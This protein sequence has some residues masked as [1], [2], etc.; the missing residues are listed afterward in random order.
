MRKKVAYRLIYSEFWTDPFIQEDMTPEDR[1]F[2][3]YI[4][5]NPHTTMAGI[6][7]ITK[8]QIAFELGYSIES[9]NSL[10]DRFE[11]HHKLIK[12]NKETREIAIKNWGK[13]NLNKGGKPVVDCLKKELVSIKDKTLIA[14]VAIYVKSDV[15][16]KLYESYN[17]SY[18]ESS[19]GQLNTSNKVE[20]NVKV[21]DN[22][23]SNDTS[24]ESSNDSGTIQI[25]NTEYKYFF[26]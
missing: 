18:Y 6:Y 21:S 3:L 13:H 17:E 7:T 8:K 25:Q 16:K 10:I 26:F 12:Y 4:L 22:A 2:Y 19:E 24:H 23:E 15:L 5:T 1:Y 20:K 9:V 11:N 14:Y